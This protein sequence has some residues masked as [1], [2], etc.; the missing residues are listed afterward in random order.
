MN[1]QNTSSTYSTNATPSQA[2]IRELSE[3]LDLICT[4]NPGEQITHLP[5]LLEL[6]EHH[7][8]WP[9]MAELLESDN[10]IKRLFV[11]SMLLIAAKTTPG[12]VSAAVQ[13]KCENIMVGA[14]IHPSDLT[15]LWSVGLMSQ[16][17]VPAS[18]LDKL[19]DLLK[20]ENPTLSVM[21]A[22]V[23]TFSPEPELQAYPIL[24]RALDSDDEGI[25]GSAA[26]ALARAGVQEH[27]ALQAIKKRFKTFPPA[28]M[29][30]LLY[31]ICNSNHRVPGLFDEVAAVFNNPDEEPIT[32]QLAAA[33]LERVAP[34]KGRA[35]SMLMTAL[36]STDSAL[37]SGALFGFAKF[38]PF[39][40]CAADVLPAQLR[41]H[42]VHIRRAVSEAIFASKLLADQ[43]L[44]LLIRRLGDE[45]DDEVIGNLCGACYVVGQPAIAPLL[46]RVCNGTPREA[47]A[48]GSALVTVGPNS[49]TAIAE[50]LLGKRTEKE[51]SRL[52][53]VLESMGA[54]AALAIPTLAAIL[55]A[56]EDHLLAVLIIR[57]LFF[58]EAA[59]LPAIPALVNYAVRADPENQDVQKWIH[60][61]LSKHRREAA[62][63]LREAIAVALAADR[64][65]FEAMLDT[66]EPDRHHTSS[67]LVRFDDPETIRRFV[68]VA[69]HLKFKGPDSIRTVSA[70]LTAQFGPDG[71]SLTTLGRALKDLTKWIGKPLTSPRPAK[72]MGLTPE[73]EALLEECR[74]FLKELDSQE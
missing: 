50:M 70:S 24:T 39:P 63:A 22:A 16:G 29:R 44:P 61:T 10:P 52:L 69:E 55:S 33:A 60:S 15:K 54:E 45:K 23:L 53:T 51:Y 2:F 1:T 67:R 74:Q 40:Q 35:T 46:E 6:V 59:A 32:R 66:V 58:A 42:D 7:K 56:T 73:G 4:G 49:A 57:V 47:W 38:D 28:I 68:R 18:A 19:R 17:M 8:T 21:A 64:P 31:A 13:E 14:L 9:A 37:V 48:A 26:A 43:L 41:A 62:N 36:K 25:A 34:D 11:S 65:R 12:R 30:Y 5:A 71:N 3:Q 27:R 20:S 72:T